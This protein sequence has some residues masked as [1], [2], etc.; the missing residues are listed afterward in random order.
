M[1]RTVN[2]LTFTTPHKST[3]S[4]IIDLIL[5]EQLGVVA[6][7]TQKPTQLPH[8]LGVQYRRPVIEH[9]VRCLGFRTAKPIS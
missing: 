5:G 2:S 4:L 9:P 3:S 7:V 6:E 8:S 1:P